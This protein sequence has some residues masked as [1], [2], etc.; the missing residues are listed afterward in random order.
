MNEIQFDINLEDFS[1]IEINI[2][3]DI[4]KNERYCKPAMSRSKNVKYKNASQLSKS[5]EI[6]QKDNAGMNA[7]GSAMA[8]KMAGAMNGAGSSMVSD[9]LSGVAV[10]PTGQLQLKNIGELGQKALKD[11]DNKEFLKQMSMYTSGRLIG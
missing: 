11:D 10:A 9:N 4:D 5:I 3:F 1:G 2:D 8:G 6:K 7:L